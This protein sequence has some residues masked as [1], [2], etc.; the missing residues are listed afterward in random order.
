MYGKIEVGVGTD[1][2]REINIVEYIDTKDSADGRS[3]SVLKLEG[4]EYAIHLENPPESGRS[5]Q[6]IWMSEKTFKML[7]IALMAYGATKDWEPNTLINEMGDG[8]D[9]TTSGII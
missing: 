2:Q 8:Y 1:Q 3:V 4:S 5:T 6:S 9:V 7:L